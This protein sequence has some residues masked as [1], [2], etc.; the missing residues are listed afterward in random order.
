MNR[1]VQSKERPESVLQ[2]ELLKART[3]QTVAS[4]TLSSR[5]RSLP[6]VR[7]PSGG[8]MKR[9]EPARRPAYSLGSGTPLHSHSRVRA[10]HRRIPVVAARLRLASQYRIPSG[11]RT[12]AR[13]GARPACRI[14]ADQRPSRMDIDELIGRYLLAAA[15]HYEA[16]ENLGNRSAL[17]RGNSAADELRRLATEVGGRGCEDIE[18]FSRLLCDSR[19]RVNAWAAFH[20]LEVMQPPP[21]VVDRAFNTL[22]EIARGDDINAV[23]TRMRLAQLRKQYGLAGG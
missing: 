11:N 15:E 2:Y 14:G 18:Q 21:E 23:G 6:G 12:H 13:R 5:A 19:N 7:G 20:I 8:A 16:Q 1:I 3:Y 22:E 10:V 4:T 17:K 9:A